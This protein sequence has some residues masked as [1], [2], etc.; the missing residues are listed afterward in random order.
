MNLRIG[1]RC[2]FLEFHTWNKIMEP[3]GN[4]Y[5]DSGVVDFENGSDFIRVKLN[6]SFVYLY[7]YASEGSN[8]IIDE[9]L[10]RM[11]GKYNGEYK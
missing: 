6:D 5:G 2:W 4:I 11:I 10:C 3:Y 7:I 9:K 8:N 1:W